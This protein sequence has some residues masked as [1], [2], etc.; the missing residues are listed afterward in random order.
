MKTLPDMVRD[1][2]DVLFVG[3]NPGAKSALIGHYFAGA[4]NMFWRLMHEAGFTGERLTTETD[5]RMLDYGY[6]LTD[7]VKRPTRSTADLRGADGRGARKRLD[8]VIA[9]HRPGTVAF[10]GKAGY[11]YYLDSWTVPLRYGAQNPILAS[12]AYL[13]P[14]T[15]GASFADTKYAEKLYWYRQLRLSLRH[16]RSSLRGRR[17][18]SCKAGR[19]SG[20]EARAPAGR[21]PS[22]G[23]GRQTSGRSVFYTLGAPHGVTTPPTPLRDIIAKDL[24]VLFVGTSPGSRSSSAQHYFA[25]SSNAFWKILFESGL[26]DRRLTAQQDAEMLEYKYGL[27]DVVKK[28]T[29]IAKIRRRDERSGS[30]KLDRSMVRFKPRVAAFVG[31]RG[32]QIYDKTPRKIHEYGYQRTFKSTRLYLLPS[33]SGQSY[34]DTSYDEKLYWYRALREYVRDLPSGDQN[35]APKS[36]DRR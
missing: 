4:S 24:S 16:L 27:T 26:T 36:A 3:T 25:G 8:A 14:S 34:R 29:V 23:A 22:A 30:E 6:G 21:R 9:R 20:H 12:R 1:G 17:G 10:V 18:T 11:R 5:R 33:T 28:P 32:W 19:P 15:S 31:K 7:V 13:L 2:L 35:P